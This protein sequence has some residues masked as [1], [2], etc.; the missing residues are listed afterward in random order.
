MENDTGPYTN[1]FHPARSL[2]P[3]TL[4]HFESKNLHEKHRDIFGDVWEGHLPHSVW[5]AC[6]LSLLLV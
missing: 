4:C 2:G 6:A 1:L 3:K 5:L